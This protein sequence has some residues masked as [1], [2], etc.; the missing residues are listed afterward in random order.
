MHEGGRGDGGPDDGGRGVG[1]QLGADVVA[2]VEVMAEAIGAEPSNGG[3]MIGF[4]R[5]DIG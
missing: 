4:R 3:G 2:E 1:P 5:R